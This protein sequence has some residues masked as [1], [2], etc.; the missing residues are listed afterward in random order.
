MQTAY[1][2]AAARQRK[3]ER[4]VKIT[5]I[6]C[7]AIAGIGAISLAAWLY[8]SSISNT[9]GANI[10]EIGKDLG[11]ISPVLFGPIIALLILFG[12]DRLLHR[13]YFRHK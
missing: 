10:S 1:D 4:I 7:C 5:N 13:A 8:A 3:S 9:I 12:A 2:V 6:T 11:S